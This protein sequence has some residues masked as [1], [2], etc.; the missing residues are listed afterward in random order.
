MGQRPHSV[1]L[2]MSM[3]HQ[4]VTAGLVHLA[5][6]WGTQPF[7][8]R[9]FNLLSPHEHL[10]ECSGGDTE[11]PF[12]P[13]NVAS[14]ILVPLMEP[15]SRP[16]PFMTRSDLAGW[17]QQTLSVAQDE[18][19]Y[20]GDL[21][22]DPV[23][24][25]RAGLYHLQYT[26]D[27]V[28]EDTPALGTC[29][30]MI[31]AG[32]LGILC[33]FSCRL[34]Q[35]RLAIPPASRCRSCS[36]S[37]H[38]VDPTEQKHAAARAWRARLIRA[39]AS[40]IEALAD[41]DVRA[42][43][44]RAIASIGWS[45]RTGGEAHTQWLGSVQQAL[46][47]APLVQALLPHGF[48]ELEF[49]EQVKA[50]QAAIS[51]RDWDHAVWPRKIAAAQAWLTSSESVESRRRVSGRLPATLALATSA[52]ELLHKGLSKTHVAQMLGISPSHLSHVLR[53][54]SGKRD[55]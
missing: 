6:N 45:M 53:R 27:F 24:L 22:L 51:D 25:I 47:A 40:G 34:C 54:T 36:R 44:A 26:F 21:L 39:G 48:G 17:W 5:C 30:S 1:D 37:K 3:G 31:G 28:F 29:L 18:D 46:K 33:A 14:L 38:M 49:R 35:F 8:A 20:L 43:L 15:E 4:A 42:S 10:W 55:S 41:D 16:V 9:S 50:L 19:I 12:V 32:S 23:S 13:M 7:N 2:L 11:P 52:R